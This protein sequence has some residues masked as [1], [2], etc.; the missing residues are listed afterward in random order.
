MS[1]S[2]PRPAVVSLPLE[3]D[4]ETREREELGRLLGVATTL[5]FQPDARLSVTSND[6]GLR[7][8]GEGPGTW[9][10][11]GTPRSGGAVRVQ[12][13]GAS[14]VEISLNQIRTQ[15]QVL[16]ALVGALPQGYEAVLHSRPGSELIFS[17]G[18]RVERPA[19]IDFG[20]EVNLAND[21][22]Q[23]VRFTGGDTL[24]ISGRATGGGIIPSMLCV[25]IDGTRL[26]LA[27]VA[28]ESAH[29]VAS[30]LAA[31]LPAG[32]AARVQGTDPVSVQLH[33]C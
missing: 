28:G 24:S 30:K 16:E 33:R 9:R 23:R 25:T 3:R 29:Q 26:R 31:A 22:G 10:F 27:V 32:F 18:R 4:A 6:P 12:L 1:L 20:V 2:P 7:I 21:P 14:A 11:A 8:I 17:L 5:S 15:H 13:P 19:P